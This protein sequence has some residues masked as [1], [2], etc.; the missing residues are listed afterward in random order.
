M[1]ITGIKVKKVE[2]D[3]KLKAWASITFDEAFVVHNVKVIQGQDAMFIA[4]PNRLTKS[5]VFKDIAHP[6]TTDFRDIL[7]GKV[8][9]AYHNTNGDEHS[10]ES[11]NW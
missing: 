9:D 1:E 4:M 2:N 10:E 7:Q 5:G 3:S 11:F 8:L 6:I